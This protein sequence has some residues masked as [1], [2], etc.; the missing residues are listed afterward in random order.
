MIYSFVSSWTLGSLPPFT[1]VNRVLWTPIHTTFFLK[2]L[3]PI[4]VRPWPT[5]QTETPVC[6][7]IHRLHFSTG[8]CGQYRVVSS[9]QPDTFFLD[10]ILFWMSF[11]LTEYSSSLVGGS[12]I[13]RRAWSTRTGFCELRRPG[14]HW[15][16][17]IP[18]TIVTAREALQIPG[19][20]LISKYQSVVWYQHVMVSLLVASHHLATLFVTSPWRVSLLFQCA[21]EY[22]RCHG[23]QFGAQ[24][25]QSRNFLM[26]VS[27]FICCDL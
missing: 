24:T 25:K 8:L 20:V 4:V 21:Q 7:P 1:I 2:Y 17:L 14:I 5:S 6:P 16:G 3:F 18:L 13:A 9:V 11:T 15:I 26:Q 22:D 12:L 27:I 10:F 23:L 19:V